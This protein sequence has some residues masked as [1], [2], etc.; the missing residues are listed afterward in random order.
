MAENV[1]ERVGN[2]AAQLGLVAHTLHRERL[3][4]ARLTV[5]EHGAVEALEHRLDDGPS[6]Q[7]VDVKLLGVVAEHVVECVGLGWLGRVGRRIA[8]A[9]RSRRLVHRDHLLV[10]LALLLLVEGTR[11]H[12]Y[13]HVVGLLLIR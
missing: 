11:A 1:S 10:A 6:D 7:V 12:A 8:H 4:R 9:D 13:F 2:D 3:A 5:G